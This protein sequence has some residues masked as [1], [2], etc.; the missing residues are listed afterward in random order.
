VQA[1]YQSKVELLLAATSFPGL[2]SEQLSAF[3]VANSS[4]VY[5][6]RFPG[7][8]SIL[9]GFATLES[10]A[11]HEKAHAPPLICM[12]S[13]CKYRLAFRSVQSLNKHVKTFHES[14]PRVVP[15]T[16][17]R[18]TN[19]GSSLPGHHPQ[20]RELPQITRTYISTP[21]H[22]TAFASE[23]TTKPLEPIFSGS[24][25][26]EYHCDD[27][28][29]PSAISNNR[30]AQ[31]LLP[32][33]I[34]SFYSSQSFPTVSSGPT[35]HPIPPAMASTTLNHTRALFQQLE[36]AKQGFWRNNANLSE[37]Q[38]QHLWLQVANLSP[39]TTSLST[40]HASVDH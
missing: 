30:L 18:N 5:V 9:A 31:H 25:T 35:P 2:T 26:P 17:R 4:S 14:D 8:T 15:R 1:E 13:G 39:S 29:I 11:Q 3:K 20:L 40:P 6:C 19:A 36:Q 10:R 33:D 28:F 27:H 32:N 38:R 24:T 12:H 7:C 21:P 16:I 23:S 34:A 22:T 37:E